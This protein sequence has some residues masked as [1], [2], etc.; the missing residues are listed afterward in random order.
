MKIIMVMDQE[1]LNQHTGN[2]SF[3]EN[4]NGLSPRIPNSAHFKPYFL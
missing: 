3:Y 4:Y 2:H 1:Y